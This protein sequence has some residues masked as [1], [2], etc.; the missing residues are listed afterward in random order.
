MR[1]I[2]Q[3]KQK[4]KDDQ[5]KYAEHF[6]V[7]ESVF[8]EQKTLICEQ[9]QYLIK[10]VEM[11]YSEAKTRL[12]NYWKECQKVYAANVLK[13]SQQLIRYDEYAEIL[14]EF[15][16]NLLNLDYFD[17]KITRTNISFQFVQLKTIGVD[18]VQ[19]AIL[20]VNLLEKMWESNDCDNN[21]SEAQ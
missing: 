18:Q 4:L 9:F 14:N 19:S 3:Y 1:Q 11:K 16:S 10:L 15:T 12:T 13:M 21:T 20:N 8:L 6:Q 17:R 5:E 7:Q 2:E